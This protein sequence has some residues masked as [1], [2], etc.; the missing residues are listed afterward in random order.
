M[1]SREREFTE[2]EFLAHCAKYGHFAEP[3]PA[4]SASWNDLR[5]WLVRLAKHQYFGRDFCGFDEEKLLGRAAEILEHSPR[6][7]WNADGLKLAVQEVIAA[8]VRQKQ[9]RAAESEQRQKEA[10]EQ[11]ERSNREWAEKQEQ[12][13]V[14]ARRIH[15]I[16]DAFDI[17]IRRAQQINSEGT[18]DLDRARQLCEIFPGTG[19]DRWYRSPNRPGKR[20]RILEL[21]CGPDFPG[22]AF[23]DFAINPDRTGWPAKDSPA[24]FA[25]MQCAALLRATPTLPRHYATRADLIDAM[26]FSEGMRPLWAC[27]LAWRIERVTEAAEAETLNPD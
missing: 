10:A 14:N 11:I 23:Y 15:T 25:L 26:G 3:F 2:T 16:A 8:H 18:S 20:V 5:A 7:E 21:I 24:R 12:R 1:D 27:Y 9:R 6:E 22:C 19:L 17:T 13:R 4:D